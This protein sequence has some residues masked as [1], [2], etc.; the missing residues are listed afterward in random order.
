MAQDAG[1]ALAHVQRTVGSVAQQIAQN[2][3]ALPAAAEQRIAPVRRQVAHG[4]AR[5]WNE[6]PVSQA[7]RQGT[8]RQQG[9]PHGHMTLMLAVSAR[10]R[11]GPGRGTGTISLR[12]P[13]H[14]GFELLPAPSP[15]TRPQSI[16]MAHS[17]AV[18]PRAQ[19]VMD[20]AMAREEVKARLAPVP[21][22]T[23]ANP[24]NEFV[25]VAGEVRLSFRARGCLARLPQQAGWWGPIANTW[26]R[27]AG[28]RS[29]PTGPVLRPA[30][31]HTARLFLLQKGGRRGAGGEGAG[32]GMGT[33]GG[34][35]PCP[36]MHACWPACMPA[37]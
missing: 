27:A 19:P 28:A 29:R 26:A 32:Q 20:L 36:C 2:W 5:W 7:L 21:V 15:P 30:E 11:G 25:L 24:K 17:E 18:Q 1:G 13:R 4:L 33:G 6:T 35:C 31:Q 9:E 37:A 14:G 16:S 34:E 23:V 8:A 3:G 10:G 12:I 22:F